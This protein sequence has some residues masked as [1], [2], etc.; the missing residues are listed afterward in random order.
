MASEDDSSFGNHMVLRPDKTRAFHLFQLLFRKKLDGHVSI[1]TPI[2]ME[3][4]WEK[5]RWTIFI[6][7]LLQKILMFIR[8]PMAWF[9][10]VIEYWMNLVMEN[11]GFVSLLF[12]IL[13]G[14]V[15]F[16]RKGSS[17]YRSAAGFC[18]TRT[19]LD[20]KIRPTDKKYHAALSIMAAKLAYENESFV[21]SIVRHQ[22]NMEFLGFYNCWNDYQK[23]FSTQAFMFSDKT[24][25]DELIVVAFRGTEPFDLVQWCTDVDISYYQIPNVGKVHEGF[26]RAL[27]LQ[28]KLGLPKELSRSRESPPPYAYYVIRE[29]LR[30]E[31]SRNER[32]KFLVAG[33]SLGGALAILFP[34]IL[35]VHRENWLLERLQGV[36]TFGQPRV[37]DQNFGEFVEQYL[38]NPKRRRY[39]RYVYSNDIVSRVPYD[40]SALL[41]KHFG[42]CV[43]FNSFYKPKVMREEPNKN[44]FSL[45][46][47]IPKYVNAWWE[48]IRGF[49][50]G[51]VK[52]PEYKEGW[53]MRYL[54]LTALVFPGLP[55][56]ALQDYDNCTRLETSLM[57][58]KRLV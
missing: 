54:R 56:H 29:K 35:A 49:L 38:D 22:W 52:G 39:F 19:E 12:N 51:F 2:G 20:W 11:H 25:D 27:G 3:I 24:G 44:Y 6:S 32:A 50:I 16:P 21:Q 8:K 40:D 28:R 42:T 53:L 58:N 23:Q 9:G 5:R 37:G 18:D 7:V 33:H 17:T 13:K 14:R 26:L 57:L 10:S 48:L 45:W 47:V 4:D 43:Y 46:T 30:E 1:E 55:P 34:S 36:Y 41:Y 15:V 31:L